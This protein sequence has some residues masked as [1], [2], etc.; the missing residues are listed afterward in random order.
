MLEV[1]EAM[2]GAEARGLLEELSRGAADDWLTRQAAAA[3]RR[4][5]K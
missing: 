2:G 1:L 5:G 3:L 4:P